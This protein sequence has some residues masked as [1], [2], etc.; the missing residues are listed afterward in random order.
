MQWKF[1][2]VECT[3][4]M[5]VVDAMIVLGRVLRREVFESLLLHYQFFLYTHE[6]K[7]PPIRMENSS[8]WE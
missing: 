2:G 4:L 1:K 5:V 3:L 6:E 7:F 8:Q